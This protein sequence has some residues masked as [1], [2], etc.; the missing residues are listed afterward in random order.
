MTLD[1]HD[2]YIFYTEE[3]TYGVVDD[4]QTWTR[5][6][7][8]STA[9][10][11]GASQEIKDMRRMG[12]R[13]RTGSPRGKR[14]E[15]DLVFEVAMVDDVEPT[16]SYDVFIQGIFNESYDVAPTSYVFLIAN[17]TDPT[18][19]TLLE[20]YYGCYLNELEITIEEGEPIMFTLT[21]QR[22]TMVD[23]VTELH[24]AT[25]AV[26]TD[27]T[28]NTV[29]F[30]DANPDT[31]A[32]ASGDWA[33]DGLKAGMRIT[34]TNSTSNNTT[35][36]IATV[37]TL[38]LTLIAADTVV[39][40]VNTT[41]VALTI[42]PANVYEAYPASIVYA[43]WSDVAISK[44]GGTWGSTGSLTI[45]SAINITVGQGGDKKFRLNQSK[46][47]LGIH[48]GTYEV[49]GTMSIDLDDLLQVTELTGEK[50]GDIILAITTTNGLLA[51]MTLVN[52]TFE[53]IP[54]DSEVNSLITTD[55]DYTADSVTFA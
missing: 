24:S 11:R 6:L 39:G 4:D 16:N 14:D 55:I 28:S 48:H 12:K 20:Y 51:T 40:E 31:I 15:A 23:S 43:L 21:F 32:R 42:T 19:A 29:T 25:A 9:S 44:S 7:E 54:Y 5:L 49:S 27:A 2:A 34:I 53:G 30:A 41:E 35:Y 45:A 17:N 1:G 47:P 8:A 22:Q 10:G 33:A 46:L 38:T 36:T 3:T 50:R 26:V 52:T 13:G 18:S 37:T